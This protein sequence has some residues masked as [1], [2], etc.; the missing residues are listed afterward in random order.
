[1][2][3]ERQKKAEG[4][5]PVSVSA[6]SAGGSRRTQRPVEENTHKGQQRS[7]SPRQITQ[8]FSDTA[9]S[10]QSRGM[11]AAFCCAGPRL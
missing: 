7:A 5:A 2:T 1:M 8:H 11:T 4:H 9:A 3:G 6:V 10:A